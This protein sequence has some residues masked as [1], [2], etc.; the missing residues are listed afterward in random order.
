MYK[1]NKRVLLFAF[2]QIEK[3]GKFMLGAKIGSILK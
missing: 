2:G 1:I 3:N